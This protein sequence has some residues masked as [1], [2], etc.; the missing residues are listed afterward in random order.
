MFGSATKPLTSTEEEAEDEALS[1]EA[2]SN[3]RKV[4]ANPAAM[5]RLQ[6]EAAGEISYTISVGVLSVVVFPFLLLLFYFLASGT[7]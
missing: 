7:H 5:K 6:E 3:A 4:M 1:E 2:I